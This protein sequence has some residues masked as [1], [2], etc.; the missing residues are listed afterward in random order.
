MKGVLNELNKELPVV[1]LQDWV[2]KLEALSHSPSRK[3][4]EEIVCINQPFTD[5]TLRRVW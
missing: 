5:M 2:S 1:S 3:D 4:L